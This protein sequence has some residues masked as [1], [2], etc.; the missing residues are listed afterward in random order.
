MLLLVNSSVEVTEG[1][2]QRRKIASSSRRRAAKRVLTLKRVTD[3]TRPRILIRGL[4]P[5]ICMVPLYSIVP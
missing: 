4:V 1:Q 3:E 2:H 5:Y